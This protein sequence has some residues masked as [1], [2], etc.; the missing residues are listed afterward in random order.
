MRP[1][2][3]HHDTNLWGE[4]PLD[5][6]WKHAS[7]YNPDFFNTLRKD[8]SPRHQDLFN[9]DIENVIVLDEESHF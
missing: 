6:P 9:I 2:R 4:T 1:G 8:A 3:T 5:A 7:E